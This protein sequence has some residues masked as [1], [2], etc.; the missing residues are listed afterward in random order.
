MTRVEQLYLTLAT[1]EIRYGPKCVRGG[2]PALVCNTLGYVHAHD[3]AGR[4]QNLM[5]LAKRPVRKPSQ[6]FLAE[7]GLQSEPAGEL[8]RLIQS[9]EEL[10]G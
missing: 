3:F 1:M 5:I 2:H 8:T 9:E 10:S 7:A 4:A 6:A